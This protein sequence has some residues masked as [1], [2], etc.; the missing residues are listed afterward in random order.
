MPFPFRRKLQIACGLITS[1]PFLGLWAV[2]QNTAPMNASDWVLSGDMKLETFEGR[3]ALNLSRG[4]AELKAS[5]I[6]RGVYSFDMWFE[7]KRQFPGFAFRGVDDSNFESFYFRPHQSGNPDSTQYTPVYNGSSAWQLYTGEGF[8]S[9]VELKNETWVPVR[10]EV[11]EDSA[12]IF[13]NGQSA[14]YIPDLNRE[15]RK[16]YFRFRSSRPGAFVSNFSYSS[17]PDLADPGPPE[18]DK[19]EPSTPEHEPETWSYIADWEISNAMTRDEAMER[20]QN[21]DWT[22]LGWGQ[23]GIEYNHF[24]NIAKIATRSRDTPTAI[25]KFTVQSDSS[26]RQ[27]VQFGFSDQVEIFVN[28]ELIYSGDDSYL[29]RDYRF[30]GTVG[31]YDTIHLPLAKGDN[32][33][34]FVVT[35]TFGGWAVGARMEKE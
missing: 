13:Y 10:L 23:P 19:E 29:S 21:Q 27:L 28:G 3:T 30:L 32:E 34:V 8:S 15:D 16:G 22:G 7:D 11:Y 9:A 25:A 14:L 26:Q 24:A 6:S 31:F 18:D 17:I 1:F 33:I 2:A 5:D 20:A 4:S 12:Q 35:E